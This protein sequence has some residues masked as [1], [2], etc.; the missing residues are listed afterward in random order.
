MLRHSDDD[1]RDIDG[2]W[3]GPPRLTLPFPIP[4]KGIPIGAAVAVPA[5]V[6]L[7][8][9]GVPALPVWA[10]TLAIAAGAAKAV[11]AV[12]GAERPV[13]ALAALFTGEVSAPRPVEDQPQSAVFQTARARRG[14]SRAHV[15]GGPR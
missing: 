9:F 6:L 3:W 4:M 15:G 7:R 8:A 1:L 11:L 5:A 2:R 12:T 13:H 14:H 10:L